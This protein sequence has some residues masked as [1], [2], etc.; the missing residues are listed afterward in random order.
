VWV[1][2][3]A[4]PAFVEQVLPSIREPFALV[5]GDED[6]S[7]P[8]DVTVAGELLSN[9]YLA[10]WFAQNNDGTDT[11]GRISGVPIGLDFHTIANGRKWGHWRATPAAQEAQLRRL[12]GRM[13][14]TASRE[15][16]VHADFHF[17][18]A[19]RALSGDTRAAVESVLRQNDRVVFQERTARRIDLWASRARFAFV[20]SPHGNG[21]D[22]HRTWEAL[23]LGHIPI[24]RTSSLDPLYEGLPVAIV[25]RWQDITHEALADWHSRFAGLFVQPTVQERLTNRWWISR[26]RETVAR[27]IA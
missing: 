2:Q 7:V 24:V 17:N 21:L 20:A 9:R 11:S 14:S 19:A 16:L 15:P 13:A 3:T 4:L 25:Q 18:K 1:R 8:G 12:I 5:T 23:V 10:H 22:C 6:G 26:M 27:K